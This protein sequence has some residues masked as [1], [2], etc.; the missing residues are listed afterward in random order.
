MLQEP[1]PTTDMTTTSTTNNNNNNPAPSHPQSS[2]SSSL[3]HLPSE[4]HLQIARSLPQA[5]LS[6]LSRTCHHFHRLLTPILYTSPTLP[7]FER[8]LLFANTLYDNPHR[9]GRHIRALR[10][11]HP[12]PW[13]ARTAL[14]AT[15]KP[16]MVESVKKAVRRRWLL[17]V[18]TVELVLPG[19]LQLGGWWETEWRKVKIQER[20]EEEQGKRPRGSAVRAAMGDLLRD[21]GVVRFMVAPDEG[22]GWKPRD[23]KRGEWVRE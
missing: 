10:Y 11:H 12:D 6:S 22:M 5:A 18:E 9:I 2:S 7:T 13:D 17:H 4:L 16:G 14:E 15:R 21:E 3:L 20:E 19:G 23:G 8:L 1:I